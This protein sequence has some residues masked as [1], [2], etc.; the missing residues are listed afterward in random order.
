MMPE[1][2]TFEMQDRYYEA[3]CKAFEIED[4]QIDYDSDRW[5]AFVLG[6][7]LAFQTQQ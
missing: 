5:R 4:G 3:Y 7:Q 6:L 2:D 1:Q